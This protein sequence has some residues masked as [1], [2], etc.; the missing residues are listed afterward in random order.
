MIARYQVAKDIFQEYRKETEA[1]VNEFNNAKT[2]AP[3][4]EFPGL[5]AY[6]WRVSVLAEAWG[7]ITQRLTGQNVLRAWGEGR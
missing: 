1:A 6:I 5:A 2:I 7:I 3:F 4:R